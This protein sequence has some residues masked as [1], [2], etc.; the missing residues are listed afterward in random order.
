MQLFTELQDSLKKWVYRERTSCMKMVPHW[1]TY[2][3]VLLIY[4]G[5]C[6]I[7]A[8]G[9]QYNI[10]PPSV[11]LYRPYT[12]HRMEAEPP[13]IYERSMFQFGLHDMQYLSPQLL[14]D[15]FMGKAAVMVL[16]LTEEKMRQ[17]DG[18]Y[19][20]LFGAS[21]DFVDTQLCIA[22]IIH[23]L[24]RE[25]QSKKLFQTDSGSTYYING[26]L[27]YITENMQSSLRTVEVAEHFSVS[28]TKLNQDFRSVTGTSLRQ[29]LIELRLTRAHELL[30][31]GVSVLSA[32]QQCG[33]GSEAHFVH[34]YH[35][36]WGYTPGQTPRRG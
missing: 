21:R 14:P 22:R 24:R 4:S 20:Q 35:N 1:H 5:S 32:A 7:Y 6:R 19:R 3:E 31:S 13:S 25:A 26:V 8:C 30:E 17:L 2:Y 18:L 27:A 33:Y 34:V 29:Y 28:P 12:L 15:S 10:T 9:Q 11:V 23:V 16:P 36:R